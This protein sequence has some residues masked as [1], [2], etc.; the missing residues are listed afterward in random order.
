MTMKRKRFKIKKLEDEIKKGKH[1][2]LKRNKK[3]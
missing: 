3:R 1:K 2:H